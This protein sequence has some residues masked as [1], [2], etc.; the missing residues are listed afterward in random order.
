[1]TAELISAGFEPEILSKINKTE[2][3]FP[4]VFIGGFSKAHSKRINTIRELIEKTQI[5]VWGY[6][7]ELLYY[8]VRWFSLL[9]RVK[10][11]KIAGQLKNEMWGIEMYELLHNSKITFNF[12]IDVAKGVA[13]NMRMYEATGMGSML[14]T[15]GDPASNIFE[16]GKE[17]VYYKDVKDAIEKAKY[18]L[19]HEEERK[20]IALAGQRKTMEI[21]SYEKITENIVRIFEKHLKS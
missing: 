13:G 11:K 7:L 2:K 8:P 14:L 5:V 17:V 1:M 10:N 12:H 18:Y 9:K 19:E 4:F 21:C 16:D 15:D 6:N 3:K 20:S